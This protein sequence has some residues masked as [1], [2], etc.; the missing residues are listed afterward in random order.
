MNHPPDNILDRLIAEAQADDY[1]SPSA[2]APPRVG[3]PLIAVLLFGLIGVPWRRPSGNARACRPPGLRG[4]NSWERIAGAER[5]EALRQVGDRAG[6]PVLGLLQQLALNGPA[7]TSG[8]NCG[9]SEIA[10]GFVAFRGP[11]AL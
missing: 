11:G 10:T 6:R 9:P 5:A 7:R 4:P 1:A 8:S 3:I 2:T